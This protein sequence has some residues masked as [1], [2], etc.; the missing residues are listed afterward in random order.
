MGV[1][2]VRVPEDCGVDTEL[3]GGSR[4]GLSSREFSGHPRI[5]LALRPG[6]VE[7]KLQRSLQGEGRQGPQH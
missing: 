3:G 4:L 1:G 2:G 7:E 5:T 6:G